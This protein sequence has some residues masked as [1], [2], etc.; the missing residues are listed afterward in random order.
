[1]RRTN[2]FL[3]APRRP[4]GPGR[5]RLTALGDHAISAHENI[6]NHTTTVSEP[7]RTRLLTLPVES[8]K[9]APRHQAFRR[10]PVAQC[11]QQSSPVYSQHIGE[12]FV[13]QDTTAGSENT[14]ALQ[15]AA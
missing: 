7:G 9:H 11:R 5:N 6:G 3:N 2:N 8:G 14:R 1:M 4:A 15:R 12:R 10:Q 13:G